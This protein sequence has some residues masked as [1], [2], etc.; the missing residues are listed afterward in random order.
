MMNTYCK[1]T[2]FL[3]I[4]NFKTILS[5]VYYINFLEN[6]WLNLYLVKQKTLNQTNT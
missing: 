5:T 6:V 1:I 4:C 3:H 2:V